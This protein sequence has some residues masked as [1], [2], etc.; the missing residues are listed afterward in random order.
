[1]EP[2]WGYFEQ[3]KAYAI[4]LEATNIEWEPMEAYESKLKQMEAIEDNWV[5]NEA[6]E[7]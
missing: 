1:M 7:G 4:K 5:Q 6:N 2:N 3:I